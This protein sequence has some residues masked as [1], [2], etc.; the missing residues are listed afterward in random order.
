MIAYEIINMIFSNYIS[1]SINNPN[2]E[3]LVKNAN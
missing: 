1:L 3:N 2:F